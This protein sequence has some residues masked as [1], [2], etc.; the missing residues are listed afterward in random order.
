MVKSAPPLF[1]PGQTIKTLDRYALWIVAGLTILYIVSFPIH[2]APILVIIPVMAAGWFYGVQGGW[3]SGVV[4]FLID[5][6]TISIFQRINIWQHPLQY[7]AENFFLVEHFFV[8]IIGIGLGKIRQM[9]DKRIRIESELISRERALTILRMAT[10]DILDSKIPSRRYY[11]LLTSLVNL[12]IADSGSFLRWDESQEQA[13]LVESTLPVQ[14]QYCNFLGPSEAS[15]IKSILQNKHAQVIPSPLFQSALEATEADSAGA[16]ATTNLLDTL[17]STIF[18][19]LDAPVRTLLCI[20]LVAKKIN[21]GTVL[22]AYH[23]P[24][25]G[26]H[27]EIK[28]AEEFGNFIALAVWNSQ[29]DVEAKKHLQEVETLARISH[30]L[31]ETEKIGLQTVLQ[32]IISSARELIPG[33]EQA[34]IHLLDKDQQFLSAQAVSGYKDASNWNSV[35]IYL[36]EGIAGQVIVSGKTIN[37]ADVANDPRYITY[38]TPPNYH[39]LMVAPVQSG[40][41]KLGTISV[42]SVAVN[43]FT[44]AESRLLSALGTQAATAIENAHLLESIQQALKESNALYRINQELVASLDS[45]KLLKD[46]VELLQK[47]FGYY[48]VQI[49]ALDPET[50]DFIMREGSGEIGRQLKKQGYRLKAGEGIVGYTA[51]TNAAFFTNDVDKMISFVRNPLLPDTKSELAVPVKIDDQILGLLDIQQVPPAYLSQ[52]DLR[53]VTAVADQLA[54]SLQKANL[55]T[56]LKAALQVETAI[57]NQMVQ[58]ER[59]VTMGRL[60]ASVSHEL[61]NPLQAIQNALFLLREEKGISH[62]G[63][64]DLDIVLSEAERMSALIERLRTTYRP[65]QAE[66]FIPTQINNIIEDV[67]ALIS[68]HLRHNEITFDFHP[69]PELPLI[70]MLGDQMRQVIINLLINGV[71]SMTTGG[72]LTVSTKILRDSKEMLLTVSDTGTGIPPEILPQ[73][74]DAFVTNKRAGT[75]LGLTITYDIV[76]KHSG[77]IIAENNPD[78]GSTF[79]VWLPINSSEIE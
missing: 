13:V 37:I 75:G 45:D 76:T 74:F 52:N 33:A 43:A 56:E 70:P 68:T 12:F 16:N 67:G 11:Y 59:L 41:Q 21:L 3:I 40:D 66:D 77:R 26:I 63:R 31:S 36:N 53:L 14:Q 35:K 50:G 54:I 49:Y 46:V 61:N 79:K 71:E 60:L 29:Q 22:L 47:S 32:L 34:V 5:L 4:A 9:N 18:R 8:L 7:E 51:D 38:A 28:N 57:R 30:A 27:A 24:N 48:H 62:Q 69:E 78:K 20:P 65:I 58:S 17:N 1:T 19:N 6:V 23:L 25:N 73:I 2:K 15:V 10:N 42:Q 55:L 44:E 64:L 72:T 39:S